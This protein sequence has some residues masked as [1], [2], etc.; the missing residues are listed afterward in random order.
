MASWKEN[1]KKECYVAT[2]YSKFKVW[3]RATAI[4]IKISKC[5]LPLRVNIIIVASMMLSNTAVDLAIQAAREYGL[6]RYMAVA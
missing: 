4:L 6:K 2:K 1:F 5:F 3:E